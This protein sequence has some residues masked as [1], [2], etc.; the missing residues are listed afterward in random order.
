MLDGF[1]RTLPQAEAL[2]KALG[3]DGLNKALYINVSEGEL[4]RRLGGR[5]ICRDCQTTYHDE[6][7]P[8]TEKGKCDNCGGE[9]YQREDDRPEVVGKRIQV[10]MDE[11]APLVG[12]YRNRGILVEI[13]GERSIDEVGASLL[14]AIS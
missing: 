13:D 3:E 5:L 14:E 10:Y 7:T 2:S 1:P 4:V 6:F 11:T 12:F 9:V 8:P